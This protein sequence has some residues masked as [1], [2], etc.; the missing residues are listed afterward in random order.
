VLEYYEGILILTSCRFSSFD[1]AFKSRIKLALHYEVLSK[2]QRRKMW[3]N[4][5]KRLRRLEEASNDLELNANETFDGTQS[6][7]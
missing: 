4:F 3:K 2:T 6:L 7:D 1:E 5:L